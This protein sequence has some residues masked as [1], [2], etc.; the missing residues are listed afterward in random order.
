METIR[1]DILN[2]KAKSLLKELADLD[3]IR[4]KEDQS[5]SAFRELLGRLRTKSDE[6]PSL[7]EITSEVELVRKSRYEK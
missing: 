7:D 2:P 6:A 4:L 5:D 3:L 1:I